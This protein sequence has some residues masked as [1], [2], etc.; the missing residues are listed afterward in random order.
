[1]VYKNDLT[2]HYFDRWLSEN[3]NKVITNLF[4]CVNLDINGL[5]Y[6]PY[7]RIIFDSESNEYV[8]YFDSEK[9]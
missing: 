2:F 7:E 8:Y 9:V 1:M 6:T 5:Q 3:S 4:K